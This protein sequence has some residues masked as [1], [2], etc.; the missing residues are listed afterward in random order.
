MQSFADI[1][2]GVGDGL[3]ATIQDGQ[4]NQHVVD[5]I[6]KSAEEGTWLAP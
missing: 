5:A 4:A 2:N 6:I 3:A 1:L